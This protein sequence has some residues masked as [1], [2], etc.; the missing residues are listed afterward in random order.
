MGQRTERRIAVRYGL[1]L[2]VIV[3]GGAASYMSLVGAIETTRKVEQTHQTL[4]DMQRILSLAQ[5]AETG[6]R[7]Y[8]LTGRERYLDHCNRA[9]KE[10][11][12]R[13]DALGSNID[14]N[15]IPRVDFEE[16]RKLVAAKLAELHETVPL[17]RVN[18]FD[19]ALSVVLTDRGARF[20]GEIRKIVGRSQ[21]LGLSR[22]RYTVQSV[23]SAEDAFELRSHER[24]GLVLMDISLPGMDGKQATRRIRANPETANL[25]VIAVTT[26]AILGE[27]DSIMKSGVSALI[28]K[29]IDETRVLEAIAALHSA[30]GPNG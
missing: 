18:G 22:L 3:V 27:A 29:P 6:Q 2:T 7:G 4:H 12:R 10:I 8:V 21:D 19:A 30:G 11:E 20:M 15:P 9:I 14:H 13:L 25:P 5:D 1:A 17:R 16:L 28:T 24:F 26:H 23:G